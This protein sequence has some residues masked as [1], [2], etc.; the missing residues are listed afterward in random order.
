MATAKLSSS[1]AIWGYIVIPGIGGGFALVS[2]VTVAQLSAPPDLIAITTG[3]AIGVRGLGGSVALPIYNAILNSKLTVA[4][5]TQI[6]KQVLPRGLPASSL[7]PFITA[8][9]SNNQTLLSSVPGVTP[10]IIEAG[11]L[12]LKTAYLYSFRYVWITTAVVAAVGAVVACF[13]INPKND[14]NMHVDAPLEND[15]LPLP[16]RHLQGRDNETAT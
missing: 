6:A 4:L 14:F 2:I 3:L 12:G 7:K 8:L 5:P 11:V 16:P 13:T 15:G 1:R 10:E 9:A